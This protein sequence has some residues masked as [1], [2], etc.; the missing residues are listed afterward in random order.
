MGTKR[1]SKYL[2]LKESSEPVRG[3][4]DS[5]ERV[6]RYDQEGRDGREEGNHH[7]SH[8]E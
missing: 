8:N 2:E 5:L 4:V 7:Y 6:G 3:R 1:G